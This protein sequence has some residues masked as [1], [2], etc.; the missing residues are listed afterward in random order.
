MKR[1]STLRLEMENS[2]AWPSPASQRL[3]SE[4]LSI[5]LLRLMPS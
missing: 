2:R 5:T 1:I 3:A 4:V